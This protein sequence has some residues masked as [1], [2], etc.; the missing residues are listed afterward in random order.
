MSQ[1]KLDRNCSANLER[2]SYLREEVAKY[3]RMLSNTSIVVYVC[4][5]MLVC[6][7]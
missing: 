3:E 4:R 7:N 6:L 2:L 1:A 5:G